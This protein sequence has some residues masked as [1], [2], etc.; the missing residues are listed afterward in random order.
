MS[1]LIKELMQLIMAL[2]KKKIINPV[3][4]MSQNGQTHK[5]CNFC[6]KIFKVCLTILGCYAW[7][8]E[9]WKRNSDSGRLKRRF[10][11]DP[12]DNN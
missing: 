7:S 1:Y 6:C 8:V 4:I 3:L 12:K 5:S 2:N 10:Y 9:I 11:E